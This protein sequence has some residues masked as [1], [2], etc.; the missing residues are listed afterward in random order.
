M[1]C[2]HIKNVSKKDKKYDRI[3][4]NLSIYAYSS[5]AVGSILFFLRLRAN[6]LEEVYE[7]GVYG[8]E[9]VA[10][11]CSIISGAYFFFLCINRR[12][13]RNN[14]ALEMQVSHEFD[15]FALIFSL[16]TTLWSISY[17]IRT[18]VLVPALL[19]ASAAV[20]F[21]KRVLSTAKE[22]RATVFGNTAPTL[23]FILVI[24]FQAVAI[25]LFD[26]V[27]G[28]GPRS[29]GL[30]L[31]SFIAILATILF[32]EPIMDKGFRV[33]YGNN[34][35][36]NCWSDFVQNLV[37]TIVSLVISVLFFLIGHPLSIVFASL[38]LSCGLFLVQMTFFVSLPL[39]KKEISHNKGETP[40]YT[41]FNQYY[42]FFELG[43]YTKAHECSL[44]HLKMA[45]KSFGLNHLETADAY[46]CVGLT[47][48]TLGDYG[49]AYS[50]LRKA[51]ILYRIKL[52]GKHKF[53]ADTYL[54]MAEACSNMHN[55]DNY[56]NALK[57]YKKALRILEAIGTEDDTRA[58][59]HL[60]LGVVYYYLRRYHKAIVNSLKAVT[61]YQKS[62]DRSNEN[63]A[64]AYGNL[65][66]LYKALKKYP[67]ATKCYRQSL[68]FLKKSGYEGSEL[69]ATLCH[70]YGT[71]LIKTK[72][73]DKALKYMQKAFDIQEKKLGRT[74]PDTAATYR[75]LVE[76]YKKANRDLN[77]LPDLVPPGMTATATQSPQDSKPG[78]FVGSMILKIFASFLSLILVIWMN[79]CEGD[80]KGY[81][82]D[83]E[84]DFKYEYER[85]QK[86]N[87][88]VYPFDS[89]PPTSLSQLMKESSEQEF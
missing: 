2:D 41:F 71:L 1:K 45:K 54:E 18:M 81:R 21:V 28:Q 67:E 13:V 11:I 33:A 17:A 6:P 64:L 87:S 86:R 27:Y 66:S 37:A 12:W 50:Y 7:M 65:V 46:Y 53:L 51:L 78:S 70:N 68:M 42:E 79:T 23:F 15:S 75:S 14:D 58:Y 48:N 29:V 39:L 19:I 72:A 32:S 59:I 57:Y 74:H 52:D 69:Y 44:Q 16:T 77:A 43:D 89:L 76:I 40:D 80:D 38:C 25:W 84:Y 73:Y 30:F 9:V 49:N 62:Q 61:L 24:P 85:L 5:L 60:R 26:K 88:N 35:Q 55:N 47:C 83:N 20:V 31:D 22:T 10:I 8:I 63:I 4:K 3:S 82:S 36:R 56:W 34:P